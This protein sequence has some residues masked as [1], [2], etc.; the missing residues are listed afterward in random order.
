MTTRATGPFDVK[1]APQPLSDVAAA[2]G[3]ARMSLDKV[4]HGDLDATSQGEML[5][6]MGGVKGSAAYVALER[7]TGTLHGRT[8]SFALQHT[9]VMDRGTP[10]LVVN[11]VPDSGTGA[12]TGLTGTMSIHVDGKAHSYVF[13]Y[14]LPDTVA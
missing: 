14:T 2:T 6:A 5:S 13:D 7:V 10:S 1:L 8:G 9:G 3:L 11:V 4:F 12:L